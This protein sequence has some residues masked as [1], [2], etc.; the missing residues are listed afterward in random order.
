MKHKKKR[1]YECIVFFAE[2]K[3]E[4]EEIN[5]K[6]ERA[7]L[8]GWKVRKKSEC[9][10]IGTDLEF[11]QEVFWYDANAQYNVNYRHT[12]IKVPN[13]SKES[14]SST[15]IQISGALNEA[16]NKPFACMLNMGETLLRANYKTEKSNINPKRVRA[17]IWVLTRK[18]FDEKKQLP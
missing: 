2:G 11:K 16:L 17:Y 6:V 8:E 15:A 4:Y 3:E 1:R 10:K 7:K 13:F 9:H 5:S 18:V 12:I 14:C